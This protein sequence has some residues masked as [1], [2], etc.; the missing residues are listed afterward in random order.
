MIFAD[1]SARQAYEAKVADLDRRRDAAQKEVTAI[2]NRFRDAFAKQAVAGG[3]IDWISAAIA[4]LCIAVGAGAAVG[5]YVVAA[6]GAAIEQGADVSDA[7]L[8]EGAVVGARGVVSDSLLAA[9]AA[10]PA[11]SVS[12]GR[13]I[14]PPSIAPSIAPSLASSLAPTG[15][16]G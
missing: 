7:L 9:G 5:P 12:T 13:T 3:D 15:V 2:E 16:D 11:G 4:I 10:L 6:A 8:S 14:G 1:A